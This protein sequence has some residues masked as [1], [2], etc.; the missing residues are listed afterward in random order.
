MPRDLNE[1]TYRLCPKQVLT[2]QGN[3]TNLQSH[4]KVHHPGQL[5]WLDME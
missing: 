5:I 4:L 3:I 2:K 1:A